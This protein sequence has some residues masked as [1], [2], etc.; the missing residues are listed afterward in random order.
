MVPIPVIY[1]M[2]LKGQAGTSSDNDKDGWF[3]LLTWSHHWGFE[4]VVLPVLKGLCPSMVKVSL[5][6]LGMTLRT[7]QLGMVRLINSSMTLV[8][9]TVIPLNLLAILKVSK[10]TW[11][12][13]HSALTKRVVKMLLLSTWVLPDSYL[14]FCTEVSRVLFVTWLTSL[15]VQSCFCK[16]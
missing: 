4:Y 14:N 13:K 15:V 6:P 7:L 3:E 5:Y 9:N 1:T 12:L 10:T 2:R 16:L 8:K 11:Y